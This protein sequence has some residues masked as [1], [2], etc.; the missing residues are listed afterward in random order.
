[1]ALLHQFSFLDAPTETAVWFCLWVVIQPMENGWNGVRQCSIALSL[2]FYYFS[3]SASPELCILFLTGTQRLVLP[4][5]FIYCQTQI[6][7]S[8]HRMSVL[9]PYVRWHT[10]M[11]ELR[12]L[13]AKPSIN[14]STSLFVLSGWSRQAI[15]SVDG[16]SDVQS[17]QVNSP[18]RRES[19]TASS[20]RITY[21][22]TMVA[23]NTRSK[24]RHCYGNSKS[25]SPSILIKFPVFSHSQAVRIQYHFNLMP[26]EAN[27]PWNHVQTTTQASRRPFDVQNR[28]S[29]NI[30]LTGA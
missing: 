8:N 21:I 2:A 23:L 27:V 26:T 14:W 11:S 7:M 30:R 12:F 3:R 15:G 20:D 6:W 18:L 16:S 1:M 13:L 10:E 19:M 4:S 5:Y 9:L 28:Q 22:W 29:F 24:G 25:S 17:A